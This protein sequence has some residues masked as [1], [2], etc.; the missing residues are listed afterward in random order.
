MA[1]HAANAEEGMKKKNKPNAIAERKDIMHKDS[2]KMTHDERTNLAKGLETWW[3]R[4]DGSMRRLRQGSGFMLVMLWLLVA[5]LATAGDYKLVLGRGVEVCEA[6][7]KNL[8]SFPNDPPMVC[9]RK[10]NPK[11]TEFS[12]PSWQPLDALEHFGLIEQIERQRPSFREGEYDRNREEIMAWFKERI[13][14]GAV[15]LATAAVDIEQNGITNTEVVLQY[16]RDDCDAMNEMH[17]AHS[18][19]R[20]LYV[21]NAEKTQ[22]DVDKSK[23]INFMGR[24]D[25]IFFKKGVYLTQ[26]GGN[27]GFKNGTLSVYPP[28]HV[29][30]YLGGHCDYQYTADPKRRQP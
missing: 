9:E 15:R 17:F 19:G 8:N 24:A 12:K 28:L 11:F 30:N 2:R 29:I 22:L 27:M 5:D 20:G 7:L 25:V 3:A 14:K 16:D 10:I 21:V 13:A 23:N 1:M 18:T 26:W 4:K 6:F